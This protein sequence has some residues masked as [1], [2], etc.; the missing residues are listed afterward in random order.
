MPTVVIEGL[1]LED[2][3]TSQITLKVDDNADKIDN[4]DST[5]KDSQQ[6]ISLDKTVNDWRAYWVSSVSMRS[7]IRSQPNVKSD[8]I[9]KVESEESLFYV[10]KQLL[11]IDSLGYRWIPISEYS[12]EKKPVMN[13]K[14]WVREDAVKLRRYEFMY[15]FPVSI[16][17]TVNNASAEEVEWIKRKISSGDIKVEIKVD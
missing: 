15:N 9:G 12:N 10:G 1:K 7:N 5:N 17:V 2:K 13:I 11:E 3:R 4:R 8:A 14:G 16:V 6:N